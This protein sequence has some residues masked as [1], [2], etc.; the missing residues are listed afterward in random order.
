[1]TWDLTYAFACVTWKDIGPKRISSAQQLVVRW[2]ERLAARYVLITYAGFLIM[3]WWFTMI[4]RWS[5]SQE[6]K[7]SITHD[8][9]NEHILPDNYHETARK[10]HLMH[11]ITMRSTAQLSLIHYLPSMPQLSWTINRPPIKHWLIIHRS[12]SMNAP[13]TN[14]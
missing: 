5:L 2:C 13:S 10:N 4:S 9:Y 14:Q 8:I 7:V 11:I 6:Y 3:T 12:L 1:M